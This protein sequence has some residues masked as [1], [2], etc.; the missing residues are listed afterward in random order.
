MI[1]QQLICIKKKLLDNID[2]NPIII[3][4]ASGLLEENFKNMYKLFDM[5]TN[6]RWISSVADKYF[7]YTYIHFYCYGRHVKSPEF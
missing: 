1:R 7:I 3:D 4:F 2:I 5:H 6:F